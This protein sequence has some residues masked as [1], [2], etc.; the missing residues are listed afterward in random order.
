MKIP[1]RAYVAAST[2]VLL[3]GCGDDNPTYVP[4]PAELTIAGSY[5]LVNAF[6]LTGSALLPEQVNTYLK[7]L[8]Q[9]RDDPSGA[10][11]TV[12]DEA[13]VPLASELEAALPDV[14]ADRLKGWIN[15]YVFG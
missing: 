1:R 9:L 12:L 3:A 11:F 8:V 2:M 14:V 13:G 15:D 4:P 7:L 6:D 10:L 5:Q